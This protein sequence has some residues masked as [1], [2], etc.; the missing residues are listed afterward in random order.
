LFE[1][2]ERLETVTPFF[3]RRAHSDWL[4]WVLEA[5][6]PGL[7]VLAAIL[8]TLGRVL[9]RSLRHALAKGSHPCGARKC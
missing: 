7:I 3:V 5:G 4:E 1:G 8:G 2:A 6:L 9:V